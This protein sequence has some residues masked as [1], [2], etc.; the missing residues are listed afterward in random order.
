[1]A[2][3]NVGK[4]GKKLDLPYITGENIKYHSHSFWKII[5]QF[6]VKLNIQLPYKPAT[7]LL[8]IYSREMKT[9]GHTTSCIRMVI[10]VLFRTAP[11]LEGAQMPFRGRMDTKLVHLCHGARI[12]QPSRGRK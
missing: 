1:M 12:P 8:G 4:D 2:T 3:P 6:L 5:W 11:K 9:Y 10:V 7:V